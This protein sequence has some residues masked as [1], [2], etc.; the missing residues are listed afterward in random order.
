MQSTNLSFFIA[1]LAGLLSFASPCVLPLVPAYIGHLSSSATS[2]E[3]NRVTTFL[4]AVSFVVGFSIIFILLWASVGVLSQV[5]VNYL[6]ILRK[7]AGLV[8]ILFGLHTIGLLKIDALYYEKRVQFRG[9]QRWGYLSSVLTGMFFAAG[10]SP[11][12]GPILS[13]ILALSLG[14]DATRGT[15]LLLGYTL[16]LG[17]PFLLVGAALSS[18][19]NFLR[20]LNRSMHKTFTI[21]GRKYA[22]NAV[23]LVS[24]LLLVIMGV[25]I[26]FD[27]LEILSQYSSFFNLG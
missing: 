19:A 11:C 15:I 12:I 17:I 14:T 10:W 3:S 13:G 9:N 21:A 23:E 22:F 4:H 7:V 1:F 2:A 24:G 6:G 16:G 5:L 20:R 18:A 25:L 8:L 26:F 27:A